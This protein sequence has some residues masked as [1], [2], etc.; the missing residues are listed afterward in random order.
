M[1]QSSGVFIQSTQTDPVVRAGAVIRTEYER[2]HALLTT[3]VE[4]QPTAGAGD[5]AGDGEGSG[6]GDAEGAPDR[7]TT[8]SPASASVSVTTTATTGVVGEIRRHLTA[9]A[10]TL[11]AAAAHAPESRL[12]VSALRIARS[13]LDRHV[14]A[15][16]AA[17]DS[18]SATAAAQ[19]VEAV[20]SVHRAVEEDVLLPA[21]A[22]LP[23]GV[24][25]P[26]VA[27]YETLLRGGSLDTSAV[28]DVR[29]VPRE[30]RHP[31]V[32]AR[33]ARLT[34][35]GTFT[36]VNN[37]DPKPLHKQFEAA[38]PGAYTWD[39]VERGPAKWQIRIGRPNH[40][41]CT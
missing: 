24:L 39:Y 14:D 20:L 26:L 7:A 31:L 37:H 18:A 10:E 5:G 27:D 36:L 2:L 29:P 22:A 38:H 9:S 16:D 35:G 19:R 40:R 13:A 11:H 25:P 3:L 33:Y 15:L 8:A 41:P 12:L 32:F 34:P 17:G 21:L 4:P 30:Q 6:T 1:T 23:G 28:I